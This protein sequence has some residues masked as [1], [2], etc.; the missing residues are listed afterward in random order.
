MQFKFKSLVVAC[1]FVAAGAAHAAAGDLTLET[2]AS[3]SAPGATSGVTYTVNGLSG[4][5]SLKFSQTLLNALNLGVAVVTPEAPADV[6]ID[7]TVGGYTNINAAAPIKSVTGNFDGTTLSVLQVGT[8]GGATQ[9][10]TADED[11][12]ITS[13]GFITIKDLRVDLVNLDVYAN[14][15][16]GN[17][18]GAI[19]DLKLWHIS[20]LTGPTS[21]TAEQVVAQGGTITVENTLSGLKIYDEAFDVF[22]RATGLIDVFGVGA[23]KATNDDPAGYGT[24]TSAI[25]V[26]VQKSVATAV[27]EPSTYALMGLGL[28]GMAFLRR[29]AA[30]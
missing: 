15:V 20:S 3:I 13:G 25:T 1:A 11:G 19:N 29:R 9:T 30:K 17:N 24:I 8:Q 2:G 4:A 27:P 14:V 6:T 18:V 16:G 26:S 28:V 22:A 23:L 21:F 5:G 7:G 12:T 10:L